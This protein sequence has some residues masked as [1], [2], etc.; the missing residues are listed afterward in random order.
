[1][2]KAIKLTVF[3]TLVTS[4]TSCGF[5]NHIEERSAQINHQE[6]TILQLSK[7]KRELKYEISKLKTEIAALET[8]NQYLSVQLKESMGE[9]PARKI[10]SV[11]PV[12][13]TGDM[14]KFDVYKWTPEQML[15]VA[16]KEF[17]LKNFE[18]SAQFFDTYKHQFPTKK[19]DDQFLFQA[20]V[21]AFESGNHY[22]W[23]IT[24]FEKLVEAYPTSEFY[25]GSK[26]WMAL[27]NLKIGNEDKFFSAAE[28][29]RKKYRNTPEWKILS[30]HYEKIVQRHKKN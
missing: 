10:A 8:K 2:Y 18:K 4:V 26:L 3:A 23:A 17:S 29:F 13:D 11:A 9:K 19:M 15:A 20:G 22:D 24:N 7:E 6:D 27:A 28:E 1:M 14:V 21:A 16:K 30:S 25:R 5:M 12:Y